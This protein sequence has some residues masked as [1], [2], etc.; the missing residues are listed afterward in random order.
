MTLSQRRKV[1]EEKI[2][3][4]NNGIWKHDIS[5]NSWTGSFYVPRA[6]PNSSP[7]R[8]G[9]TVST[10][11][12]GNVSLSQS[13]VL[14]VVAALFQGFVMTKMLNFLSASWP[15]I[16]QQAGHYLPSAHSVQEDE[17]F[18][19]CNSYHSSGYALKQVTRKA[20]TSRQSP[21]ELVSFGAHLFF[22]R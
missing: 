11:H 5:L 17:S 16:T 20:T 13:T 6:N 1:K 19:P 12:R 4:L 10:H 2:N 9:P 15:K 8:K 3:S 7:E 22:I 18:S 14:S 21:A